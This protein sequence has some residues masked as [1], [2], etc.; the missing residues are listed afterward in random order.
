MMLRNT[1]LSYLV[2]LAFSVIVLFLPNYALAADMTFTCKGPKCT[3]TSGSGS[4][5]NSA[6]IYPGDTVTRTLEAVN[7]KDAL[8]NLY[9]ATEDVSY[10][11]ESFADSLYTAITYNGDPVYGHVLNSEATSFK[12]MHNLFSDGFITLGS[13]GES[14]T[15]TYTWLV[16]FPLGDNDLQGKSVS[17]DVTLNMTCPDA[18]SGVTEVDEYYEYYEVEVYVDE[19]GNVVDPESLVAYEPTLLERVADALGIEDVGDVAGFSDI[20]F[21]PSADF[22]NSMLGKFAAKA[23]TVEEETTDMCKG[24]TSWMWVFLLQAGVHL[25]L[26]LAVKKFSSMNRYLYAAMLLNFVV[27][28][29]FFLTSFCP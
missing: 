5:F 25:G 14:Q 29:Y 11:S 27:F 6:K 4:F 10:T 24:S 7:K 9:L 12:S 19:N 18:S 3:L 23:Q 16:S 21:E 28:I 22:I 8:C 17:F 20:R 2:F 26:T 1:P 13:V 15:K